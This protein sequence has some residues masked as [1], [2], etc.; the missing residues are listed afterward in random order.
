MGLVD[1]TGGVVQFL[2]SKQT[3]TAVS[4]PAAGMTSTAVG[5]IGGSGSVVKTSMGT[6]YQNTRTP[7]AGTI[8]CFAAG[9]MIATPEGERP[10]QGLQLGDMVLTLD[11]G[12]QRVCS[13]RRKRHVLS[14]GAADAIP[15][16]IRKGALGPD[17]PGSDIVVS[18]QHRI[19]VG[20]HVQLEGRF[21]TEC[22]VPAKAVVGLPGIRFARGRREITYVQFALPAHEIV[23]ANGAL[24]ET[25]FVGP[26]VLRDPTRLRR[27]AAEARVPELARATA[28]H[29]DGHGV[30]GCPAIAAGSILR[31]RETRS[32]LNATRSACA[33]SAPAAG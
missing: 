17:R 28:G 20:G 25:P 22:L 9:T 19:F 15:V 8:V 3:T 6:S 12:P 2:S 11:N 16:P 1:D 23:R 4:G 32:R 7:N 31:M 14:Q 18:P 21:D 30:S 29:V 24:A 5:D 27:A 26:L 13:L 10:A 33:L